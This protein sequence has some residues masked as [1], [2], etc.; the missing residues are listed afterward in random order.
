MRKI[1]KGIVEVENAESLGQ[2][3]E[4]VL[5]VLKKIDTEIDYLWTEIDELRSR[6]MK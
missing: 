2:L 1:K 4:G 6:E 5:V 3:K